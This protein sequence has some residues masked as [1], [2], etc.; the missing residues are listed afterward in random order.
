MLGISVVVVG[1]LKMS[2]ILVIILLISIQVA[3]AAE[4]GSGNEEYTGVSGSGQIASNVSSSSNARSNNTNHSDCFL[5]YKLT[6]LH[7]NGLINIT[8]NVMLASIV[9]LVGLE[10]ITIIGHDNPTVNCDNA[11]GIH[12]DNCHNCIVIGITWEKCGINNYSMPAM[13]VYSSSNIIIQNCSFHYSVTQAIALSEM[14]GN[15]TINNCKFL[16]NNYFV[17]HGTAI[18]FLSKFTHHS[19]F[20]FTISNCNF[21]QNG[22]S[23]DNSIVYIGPS[24][25]KLL[26]QI[27][28]TN[29]VFSSNQGVPI[30]IS[31]QHA[32]VTGIMKFEGNN[33]N[34][35]GGIFVT[36]HSY[37]TLKS[38]IKFINNKVLFDGGALSI[39][40]SN[41]TF[42]GNSTMTVDS[43]RAMRYG[44][45]LYIGNNSYVIF[46]ENSTIKII[47]TQAE[48][49]GAIFTTERYVYK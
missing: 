39:Q 46:E 6:N 42:K 15:V 7:S 37:V 28:L 47:K 8:A 20:Q 19:K 32:F 16:F 14:S 10:N 31:H 17:G 24:N 34:S 49:G 29:S 13:E 4:D 21:T 38:D 40:N 27:Y 25:N 23:I 41:I 33:A 22:A 18:H 1:I 5:H 45:A 35:G 3:S 12:F 36:N 11:G 43:N 30:Y 2:K 26:E 44:G 9:Q 48:Q